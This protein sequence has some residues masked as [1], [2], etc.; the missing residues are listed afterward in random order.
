MVDFLPLLG[1]APRPAFDLNPLSWLGSA[2]AQAI[3]DL[4]TKAMIFL[5]SAA[6]WLLKLA[7]TIIAAFTTPDVSAGGPLGSVLPTTM[8]IGA[9]LAAIMMAVQL[10]VAL[11]RRDAGSLSRVLIGIGQFGLV[12]LGYLG[13]AAGLIAAAAGLSR[14]ILQA[15]LQVPSLD[16]IDLVTDLPT[17]VADAVLATVLGILSLFVVIPA[18]FFWLLIMFVREAALLILVATSPISAGGL[19]S[20]MGRAWF[21]KTLRWFIACLLIEPVAALILGLGVSLAAGVITPPAPGGAGAPTGAL[22]IASHAG[23]AVV[24]CLLIAMAAVCPL[25]VF[26]LLAFVEPSTASGAALRSSFTENGG[27]GGLLA[28]GGSGRSAGSGSAAASAASGD[29]RSGGEAAAES[30]SGGRLAGAMSAAGSAVSLYGAGVMAAVRV[31]NRAVDVGSDVLGQGG[32]GHPSYSMTPT[33]ERASRGRR[34][35][36]GTGQ[37]PPEPPATPEQ[38]ATPPPPQ[39]AAPPPA[40]S[41]DP[42]ATG[43]GGG[44]AI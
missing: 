25:V 29:G 22:A 15:T 31:A 43:S 10:A 18:A 40:E 20:E 13:V 36:T 34:D 16:K 37:A 41:A 3:S 19:V 12:W 21:W 32:V 42:R 23:M 33:D 27:L 39:P 35:T 4:W 9:A 38:P 2:A 7:L 24:S 11:L 30:T 14:G 1:P 8:W 28:G 17:S 5:W 44:Q 6:L 26:R